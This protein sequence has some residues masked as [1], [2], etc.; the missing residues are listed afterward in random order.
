MV[1]LQQIVAITLVIYLEIQKVAVIEVYVL[2]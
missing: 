2:L 1:D